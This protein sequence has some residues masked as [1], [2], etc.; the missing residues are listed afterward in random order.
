MYRRSL[1]HVLGPFFLAVV[2]FVLV[3]IGKRPQEPPPQ[4]AP[5]HPTVPEQTPPTA[6]QRH[7]FEGTLVGRRSRVIE[8]QTLPASKGDDLLREIQEHLERGDVGQAETHLRKLPHTSLSD[9]VM[10][11]HVAVLWNNLGI[12]QEQRIGTEG[13]LVTFNEAAALDPGN[14][15]IQLNLAHA[16]WLV[17]DPH[18]TA[19][20]LKAV[21]ALAP[22]EA[23]PHLALADVLQEQDR[24]AEAGQHL[25]QARDRLATDPTLQS[26]LTSVIRKL[27]RSGRAE[28]G[29]IPRSSAHFVVK[30]D[31]A[32]D[33]TT[34][35]TVLDI[36]EDAYRD[37]G[38]ELGY[39]PS[40]PMLVVLLAKEG[41]QGAT[42]SPT[43][44]D[45]LFDP[46]LGRI[47]IPTQGALTERKWLTR[48]LR[49]EF[50]H[51]LL[52]E[53]MSA[54]GAVVPTWLNEGLA[55]YFSGDGQQ[56]MDAAI[57]TTVQVVPLTALEGTW[58]RLSPETARIAYVEA[59]SATYYLLER[60]GMQR[61]RE[62]LADL[63]T[64]GTF[65]KAME[66]KLSISY[67]Q[68]QR[69]WLDH[70]REQGHVPS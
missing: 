62:V 28:E 30:F 9:P 42:D 51:A 40:K 27:E 22:D 11:Q 54:T 38:Q 2:L 1:T 25:Q 6:S 63:K 46:V 53:E 17:R 56:N 64:H 58:N 36:L 57:G 24:L 14:A 19:D 8:L 34:W 47:Q 61:M 49:H 15:T 69:L 10:R 48:V 45:G 13:A 16:Y 68:F 23:F 44:A 26:Y 43:W 7:P 60:F 4:P 20:F 50:V 18:L 31:G 39:F 70:H 5:S 66:N 37:I 35:A 55:V 32:E 33:H 65:T 41:F 67:D 3:Q 12:L 21:I 29:L 59:T 52:H